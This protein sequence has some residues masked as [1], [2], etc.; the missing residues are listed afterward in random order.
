MDSGNAY[1]NIH[2]GGSDKDHRLSSMTG[3]LSEYH[4]VTSSGNQ[5][6]L[7]FTSNGIEKGFSALITFG[8]KVPDFLF[9]NYLAV[10]N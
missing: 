4:Q 9:L 10:F 2:D 8:I 6:Y 3:I 1:I 5:M 7:Y